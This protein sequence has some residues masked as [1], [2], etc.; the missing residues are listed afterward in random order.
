MACAQFSGFPRPWPSPVPPR[1]ARRFSPLRPFPQRRS[2]VRCWPVRTARGSA[3]R[4]GGGRLPRIHGDFGRDDLPRAALLIRG[5]FHDILQ[6]AVMVRNDGIS[7]YRP[8]TA[9]ETRRLAPVV[10]IL[11]MNTVFGG[12]R[13]RVRWARQQG[14]PCPR[15]QSRLALRA[16]RCSRNT[17]QPIV[18]R[19]VTTA[20]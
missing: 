13:A 6:I 19:I 9:V 7:A 20:L 17:V 12:F 2:P 14:R 16:A 4:R 10:R 8:G 11:D 3:P 15:R 18:R 1:S 5:Q